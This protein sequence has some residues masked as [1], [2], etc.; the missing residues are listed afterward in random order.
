M[1]FQDLFDPRRILTLLGK[2]R[3]ILPSITIVHHVKLAQCETRCLWNSGVC[4]TLRFAAWSGTLAFAWFFPGIFRI[5]WWCIIRLR[6]TR[7]RFRTIGLAWI[8]WRGWIRNFETNHAAPSCCNTITAEAEENW[9]I[10]VLWYAGS[11]VFLW[12]KTCWSIMKL[13]LW[14]PWRLCLLLHHA[15]LLIIIYYNKSSYTIDITN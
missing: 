1:M 8:I 11:W 2:I 10:W 5:I 3:L 4:Q 9:K 12:G 14:R 6:I 7:A 15:G 13:K